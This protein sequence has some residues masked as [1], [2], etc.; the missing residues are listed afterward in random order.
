MN[1]KFICS[2]IDRVVLAISYRNVCISKSNFQRYIDGNKNTPLK[3]P[4]VKEKNQ[5]NKKNILFK[6][7]EGRNIPEELSNS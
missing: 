7:K 6:G 4:T 1:L 3:T 5:F 2:H